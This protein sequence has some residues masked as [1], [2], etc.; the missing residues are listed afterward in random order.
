M[1]MPGK[2]C[3]PEVDGKI[4][5]PQAEKMKNSALGRARHGKKSGPEWRGGGVVQEVLRVCSVPAR[6]EIDEPK[7]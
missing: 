7:L 6:A 1:R 3:G 5:Q 2:V 4:L